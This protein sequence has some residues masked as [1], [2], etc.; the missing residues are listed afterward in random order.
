MYVAT[1]QQRQPRPLHEPLS[2]FEHPFITRTLIQATVAINTWIYCLLHR[3]QEGMNWD[4]FFDNEE[5]RYVNLRVLGDRRTWLWLAIFWMVC[6]FWY[7]FLFTI[8]EL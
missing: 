3:R 1:Q 7:W 6:K 5:N 4:V 2:T 8:S